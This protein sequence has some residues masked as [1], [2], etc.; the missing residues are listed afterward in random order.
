MLSKAGM[1]N[2]HTA[3][4]THTWPYGW[5]Y[6][7]GTQTQTRNFA[8]KQRISAL[9]RLSLAWEAPGPT[10]GNIS[11]GQ[12]RPWSPAGKLWLPWGRDVD[13]S[14]MPHSRTR[15]WLCWCPRRRRAG[16][17]AG[18][19]YGSRLTASLLVGCSRTLEPTGHGSSGKA[20]RMVVKLLAIAAV[21]GVAYVFMRPRVPI[22]PPHPAGWGAD[23]EGRPG[24]T[25]GLPMA[26]APEVSHGQ[27]VRDS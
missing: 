10:S 13:T 7:K 9:A 21:G 23:W 4:P 12:Q 24:R 17:L 26:Q 27:T 22:L 3:V 16:V 15:A 1:G 20:G 25:R 11:H 8:S 18:P 6:A 5:A 14:E 19:G 2:V